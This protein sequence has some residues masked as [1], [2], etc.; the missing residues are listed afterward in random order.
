MYAFL[1][2]HVHTITSADG[3][4]STTVD[5]ALRAQRAGGE[6]L[7]WKVDILVKPV[8]PG[9]SPSHASLVPVA[10]VAVAIA[11]ALELFPEQR[12]R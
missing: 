1:P 2:L 11:D 12:A 3:T 10:V 4:A 8:L 6:P 7:M 5:V 9:E